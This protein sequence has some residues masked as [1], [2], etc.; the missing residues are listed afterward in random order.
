M[1]EEELSANS[2]LERYW[3]WKSRW[4]HA[5][6]LNLIYFSVSAS[7]D[8]NGNPLNLSN[9]SEEMTQNKMNDL[10]GT[11]SASLP[12][13][14]SKQMAGVKRQRKVDAT[15]FNRSN[16]ESK[17]CGTFYFKHSDT[18]PETGSI[19]Q[20]DWSSQDATSEVCSDEEEWE[21]SKG[22]DVNGNTSNGH[23]DTVDNEHLA[24]L[25]MQVNA[26]ETVLLDTV[27]SPFADK[28]VRSHGYIHSMFI[29][30]N[31]R[32]YKTVLLITTIRFH[33][34]GMWKWEIGA[35]ITVDSSVSC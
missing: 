31:L 17:N 30:I 23:E 4:K 29:T 25:S 3:N 34:L 21:Y 9:K 20:N 28:Q 12:P 32:L 33:S 8:N 16:R 24:D 11:K 10:Y 1:V 15:K 6:K 26:N 13:T 22:S 35:T 19:K 7:T 27:D 18:E 5:P 2:K 14:P